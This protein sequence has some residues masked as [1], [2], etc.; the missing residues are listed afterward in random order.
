MCEMLPLVERILS[1]LADSM[2]LS[3]GSVVL[4]YGHNRDELGICLN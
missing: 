1:D 3:C 4:V 2:S